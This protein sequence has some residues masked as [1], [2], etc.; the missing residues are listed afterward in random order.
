MSAATRA[1]TP[2]A[3]TGGKGSGGSRGL[4]Q[5]VGDAVARIGGTS[6]KK[7]NYGALYADRWRQDHTLT[8]DA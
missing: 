8:L 2:A 1:T 6:D 7:S 3:S 4:G 5:V